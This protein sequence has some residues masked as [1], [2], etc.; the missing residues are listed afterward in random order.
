V[1]I[2]GDQITKT[3]FEDPDKLLQYALDDVEE[4]RDINR[5][6]G[7]STFYSTQFFP[8]QHQDVFRYGTGTK[9][10]SLFIRAYIHHKEAFPLADP[11]QE[12][13]GG[14][15]GCPGRGYYDGPM[16]YADVKSLYPTLAGILNI[17]P[18]KDTLGLYAPML[19]LLKEERYRNKDLA[20]KYEAEGD[21]RF[22][23]VNSLQNSIKIAINTFS[24]GW[25]GWEYGAFNDYASALSITS[26]GQEVLKKMNQVAES[27]GCQVLKYDTDGTLIKFDRWEQVDELIEYLNVN[28][29]SYI[30]ELFGQDKADLFT[31]TN[32]GSFDK[33][34]IFDRKS[35]V[36]VDRKGKLKIKGNTLKSR[37]MEPFVREILKRMVLAVLDKDYKLM[38]DWYG[39]METIVMGR[40]LTFHDVAKKVGLKMGKDEYLHKREAGRTPK[41]A[42]YELAYNRE[43]EVPYRKGDPLQYY[44]GEGEYKFTWFK[45]GNWR[46]SKVK[47]SI[48]DLARLREDWNGDYDREH[49]LDRLHKGVKRLLPVFGEEEFSSYF[50]SIKI[51]T[52][53]RRKIHA[54]ENNSDEDD[55]DE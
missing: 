22:E 23:S 44:V 16:I 12:F 53:D 33:G 34:I 2:E 37:S 51:T 19:D 10:D 43:H 52:E 21:A 48:A 35:Y 31:I 20:D 4:T 39:Q 9:I 29:K 45:N 46:L 40:S 11:K 6:L 49:Y 7:Q 32:D 26:N 13:E 47:N 42:A 38:A 17:Q 25:L 3:W 24:F 30:S 36:L 8:L 1:Y 54:D 28:V 55:S 41:L 15:A 50:P 18:P 27:F 5:I 14:Y